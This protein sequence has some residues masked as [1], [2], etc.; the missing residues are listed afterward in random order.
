MPLPVR[1]AP[2]FRAYVLPP[3]STV[4]AA[5][6]SGGYA[7]VKPVE[8]K[9]IGFERIV[10]P[11]RHPGSGPGR[12]EEHT[13]ALQSLM[14]ISYAVFCWK[15]KNTTQTTHTHTSATHEQPTS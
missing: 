9:M 4:H 14:R 5:R 7:F 6:M 13:S 10:Y 15:K 12:S 1:P 8:A 2:S 3:R 11:L